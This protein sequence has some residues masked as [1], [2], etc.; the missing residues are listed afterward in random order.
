MPTPARL[1]CSTLLIIVAPILYAGSMVLP[2]DERGAGGW[3]LAWLS[4]YGLQL[5]LTGAFTL[6]FLCLFGLVANVLFMAGWIVVLVRRCAYA[7]EPGGTG[8][9]V[10]GLIAG[11]AML[12]AWLF[13]GMT[14]GNAGGAFGTTGPRGGFSEA[15]WPG[16][17]TWVLAGICLAVA[18]VLARVPGRAYVATR[19]FEVFAPAG[20]PPLP[21][22][23][24]D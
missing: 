24:R 22:R 9:M 3:A 16:T 5:G 12:G 8:A 18:G 7:P 1:R 14:V 17:I 6:F 15:V 11:V 23:E 19:G 4:F 20:P 13:M 10:V 21:V 2:V